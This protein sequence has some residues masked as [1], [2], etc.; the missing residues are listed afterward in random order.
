V[1]AAARSGVLTPALFSAA[2]TAAVSEFGLPSTVVPLIQYSA[3]LGTQAGLFK[4]TELLTAGVINGMT[5]VVNSPAYAAG[6]Q[7]ELE[8]AQIQLDASNA[9]LN[10][11]GQELST[12]GLNIYN[13]LQKISSA[14]PG[15]FS[16]VPN[17]AGAETVTLGG[18]TPNG[19]NTL[20]SVITTGGQAV[21]STINEVSG[22]SAVETT[23]S[24]AFQSVANWSGASGTGTL[25]AESITSVVSGD[26]VQMSFLVG[27]V[28][29]TA[30]V[31]D[32]SGNALGNF[33]LI[34]ML[35]SAMERSPAVATGSSVL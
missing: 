4:G 25:T 21:S 10:A 27:G 26:S 32:S 22:A 31:V 17:G 33:S 20:S 2:A 34:R 24:P 18:G 15:W 11:A 29:T 23:S 7:L 16:T 30:A 14:I 13:E 19:F 8:N 9:L 6:Y 1:T 5:T 35:T 28:P 3:Y 12:I